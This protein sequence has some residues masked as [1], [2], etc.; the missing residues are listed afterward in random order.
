M[1]GFRHYERTTSR[2]DP[3]GWGPSVAAYLLAQLIEMQV[4]DSP[5]VSVMLLTS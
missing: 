4:R 1:R 2:G 3:P 5:V